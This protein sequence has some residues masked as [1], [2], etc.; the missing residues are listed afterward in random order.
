[1]Y[2]INKEYN[3]RVDWQNKNLL[4]KYIIFHVF[5]VRILSITKYN[6]LN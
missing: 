1:M 6:F 3:Y 4:V 2:Q 5:I